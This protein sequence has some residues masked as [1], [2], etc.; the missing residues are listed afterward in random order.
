MLYREGS[1]LLEVSRLTGPSTRHR[2]DADTH[3]PITRAINPAAFPARSR[4]GSLAL[5][6]LTLLVLVSFSYSALFLFARSSL[7]TISP[8][9]ARRFVSSLLPLPAFSLAES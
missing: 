2:V 3:Q 1:F 8:S 7:S 5:A 4:S 9:L 6:A